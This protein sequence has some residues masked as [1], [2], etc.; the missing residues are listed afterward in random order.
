[1]LNKTWITIRL[2]INSFMNIDFIN[3][4]GVFFSLFFNVPSKFEYGERL[5]FIFVVIDLWRCDN[6][7]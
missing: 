3:R 4:V 2:A 5:L 6:L 1:M 7:F